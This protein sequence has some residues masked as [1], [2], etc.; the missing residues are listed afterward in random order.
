MHRVVCYLQNDIIWDSR[1]TNNKKETKQTLH[2]G[3]TS[4]TH[5]VCGR[6]EA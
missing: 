3:T 4:N 5:T 1:T 6:H 2:S